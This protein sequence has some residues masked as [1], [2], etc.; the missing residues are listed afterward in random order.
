MSSLLPPNATPVERNL[1]AAGAAIDAI[2]VPVRD[3]GDPKKCP[4]GVLPFLAWERS[5]D[6]WDPKWPESIKRAVIDTSFFVHE[7]KGTVGAIRRVVEPL[8]Y[9][10]SVVPWYQMVPPGRR[11]TFQLEIGVLDIGITEQ[12]YEELERL[13]DDAKPLSRHMTS[14]VISM[15]T[16]SS[17]YHSAVALLGE[18]LTVYP[19]IPEEV[20]VNGMIGAVGS[21]H[22]I[23]TLTVSQ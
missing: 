2:P 8:G 4:A 3:I 1:A 12:M 18:E 7:R 17:I 16:R 21:A 6:R 15:V 5:V 11:G 14:L 20:V 22:T 9:L 23:D 13:I 10:L 19:Y